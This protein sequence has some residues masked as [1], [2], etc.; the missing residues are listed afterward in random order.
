MPDCPATLALPACSP[1]FWIAACAVMG[2]VAL[3]WAWSA[4]VCRR[5]TR[6]HRLRMHV[7]D[8]LF[9]AQSPEAYV[10]EQARRHEE[11]AL[12]AAAQAQEPPWW[13]RRRGRPQ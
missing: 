7:R 8:Q 13:R 11:N 4:F 12:V 6:E 3:W 5:L 10:M 9:A 1:W 2:A